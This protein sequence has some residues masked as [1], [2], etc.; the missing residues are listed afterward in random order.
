MEKP[1]RRSRLPKTD[2]VKKLAEFGDGH[3][4]TD[5][6][7]EREEV[8]EPV[9]VRRTAIPVPREAHEAEV[10][11]RMAGAKAFPGKS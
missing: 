11:E 7:D 1:V 3:D 2:S 10:V 9:F 5:F 4:V 6:E 8:T